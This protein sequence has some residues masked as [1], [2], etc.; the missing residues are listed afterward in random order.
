MSRLD[1]AAS[2]TAKGAVETNA[3]G[4]QLSELADDLQSLVGQFKM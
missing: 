3:A 1:E 4:G 2:Q